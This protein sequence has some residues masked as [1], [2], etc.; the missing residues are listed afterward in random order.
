MGILRKQKQITIN[1]IATKIKSR[2]RKIIL[3]TINYQKQF[4]LKNDKLVGYIF[5][6][7]ILYQAIETAIMCYLGKKTVL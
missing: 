5:V 7:M 4:V 6:Y 1:I 2:V 3:P